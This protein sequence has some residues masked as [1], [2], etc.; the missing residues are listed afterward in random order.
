MLTTTTALRI[1][2]CMTPGLEYIPNSYRTLWHE[3]VYVG[4]LY[5]AENPQS[6]YIGPTLPLGSSHDPVTSPYYACYV[7]IRR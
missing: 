2:R 6:D 5:P 4:V 3:E 1:T 7:A